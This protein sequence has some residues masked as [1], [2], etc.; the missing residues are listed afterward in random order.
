MFCLIGVN[1]PGKRPE[2]AGRLE[3]SSYKKIKHELIEKGGLV[4][5]GLRFQGDRDTK[6]CSS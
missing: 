5:G 2:P 1:L 3:H 6:E 4:S